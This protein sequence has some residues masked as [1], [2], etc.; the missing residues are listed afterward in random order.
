MIPIAVHLVRHRRDRVNYFLV[1]WG[2]IF[3]VMIATIAGVSRTPKARMNAA[4]CLGASEVQ[5]FRLIVL[6]S[7]IPT[8]RQP[9]CASRLP[10]R[11]SSAS[12]LLSCSPPI[13]ALGLPAAAIVADA[14]DRPHLRRARDDQHGGLPHRSSVPRARADRLPPLPHSSRNA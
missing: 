11:R 1:F 7:A 8:H 12:F 9:D 4:L 10:R 2:T 13:P 6:P 5:I 14:A 3:I